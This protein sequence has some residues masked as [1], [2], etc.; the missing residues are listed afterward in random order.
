MRRPP[1][2][3]LFTLG[4][5]E[6]DLQRLGALIPE[7]EGELKLALGVLREGL[8]AG[9]G[10]SID[11]HRPFVFL[12]GPELDS[13]PT[14]AFSTQVREDF[15]SRLPDTLL[16][17]AKAVGV[18][19]LRVREGRQ[20][21]LLGSESSCELHEA[22]GAT[23]L[24]VC[25]PKQVDVDQSAPYL[26]SLSTRMRSPP[27]ARVDLFPDATT[28]ALGELSVNNVIEQLAKSA[29]TAWARNVELVRGELRFADRDLELSTAARYRASSDVLSMLAAGP[30]APRA[31]AAPAFDEAPAESLL[32]LSLA[33][34]DPASMGPVVDAFWKELGRSI[35]A[36]GEP[37]AEAES[38]MKS[39]SQLFRGGALSV[40]YGLDL[41]AARD[42]LRVLVK[43]DSA[44]PDRAYASETGGEDLSD[45]WLVRIQDDFDR[46]REGLMRL[47]SNAALSGLSIVPS[48]SNGDVPS[49]WL[50]LS[51]GDAP[52]VHLLFAEKKGAL[53]LAA[54]SNNALASR[55][56][57]QALGSAGRA[58]PLREV[59]QSRDLP[60][61][62][63]LGFITPAAVA[64]PGLLYHSASARALALEKLERIVAS[65]QWRAR[66]PFTYRVMRETS[67]AATTKLSL[68]LSHPS[69][70][71]WLDTT[72]SVL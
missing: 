47:A 61:L 28:A 15:K 71:A 44:D 69:L 62:A 55:V 67:G 50:H 60:Q 4:D 32:V 12:V 33:G 16:L 39:M 13:E 66:A 18:F 19:S 23:G 59:F 53:L 29:L 22:Q 1:L 43:A 14:L 21:A 26:V 11:L 37:S 24:L 8:G 68:R 58:G 10:D 20:H 46:W 72:T 54:S 5:I 70:A 38:N 30:A 31:T 56:M 51:Y 17:E 41:E 65:P 35:G 40:A 63:G 3:A 27:P 7:H 36:A 49:S 34:T 52:P 45:F 57:A 25:G 2:A 48:R 64:A 42:R 9:I 6:G